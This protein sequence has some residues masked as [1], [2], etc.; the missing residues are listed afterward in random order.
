MSIESRAQ[1]RSIDF[2]HNNDISRNP[3]PASSLAGL[4]ARRDGGLHAT[5]RRI[6]PFATQKQKKMV[7]KKLINF[8]TTSF[9]SSDQD[10]RLHQSI[11]RVYI[12]KIVKVEVLYFIQTY[13]IM[14]LFF[15]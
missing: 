9:Y 8:C 4:R 13:L 11:I 5:P 6:M 1:K 14:I 15:F 10:I 3:D 2:Y 12:D 7:S